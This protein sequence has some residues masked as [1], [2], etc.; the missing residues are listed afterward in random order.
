MEKLRNGKSKVTFDGTHNYDR[1]STGKSLQ[2]TRARWMLL[3]VVPTAVI[4]CRDACDQHA[5]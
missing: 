3:C 5:N 4:G 2:G 1:V